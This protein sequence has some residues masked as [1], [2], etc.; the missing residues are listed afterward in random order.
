MRA[1]CDALLTLHTVPRST[2]CTAPSGVPVLGTRAYAFFVLVASYLV[3]WLS[4]YMRAGGAAF[5]VC[6]VHLVLGCR[7][8]SDASMDSFE[9]DVA[10]SCED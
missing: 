10:L 9:I 1:A 3:L 7:A 4:L 6:F 5:G 2:S 8:V